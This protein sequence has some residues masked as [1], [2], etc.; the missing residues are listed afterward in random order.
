MEAGGRG[1]QKPLGEGSA[2][3]VLQTVW[4]PPCLEQGE[5]GSWRSCRGHNTSPVLEISCSFFWE[6]IRSLLEPLLVDVLPMRYS[7]G[8]RTAAGSTSGG[9]VMC[10]RLRACIVVHACECVVH[11][12]VHV[13]M[14]TLGV[15]VYACTCVCVVQEEGRAQWVMGCDVMD[16]VGLTGE[17]T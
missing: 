15:H 10:M 1:V 9:R 17:P 2:L 8:G 12:S 16:V 3:L 14:C 5:Q 4:W 11:V 13:W 6:W 7:Q